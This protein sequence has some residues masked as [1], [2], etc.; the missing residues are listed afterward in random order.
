[1]SDIEGVARQRAEVEQ[2]LRD[3]SARHWRMA[4]RVTREEA[5]R[6]LGV[7]AN[8]I[9]RWEIGKHEPQSWV[10]LSYHSLLSRLARLADTLN[11]SGADDTALTHSTEETAK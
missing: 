2:W 9:R 3:G 5:G 11:V 7:S 8:T 1:M 6:E 10:V 4:A